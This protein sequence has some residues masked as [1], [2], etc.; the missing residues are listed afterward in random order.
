MRRLSWRLSSLELCILLCIVVRLTLLLVDK[1]GTGLRV[2]QAD[3]VVEWR[4]APRELSVNEAIRPALPSLLPPPPPPSPESSP[5]V[6]LATSHVVI[7]MDRRAHKA[8]P[9]DGA[10]GPRE[11]KREVG[12]LAGSEHEYRSCCARAWRDPS[13]NA[14]I[15]FCDQETDA[16]GDRAT[17]QLTCFSAPSLKA[18]G[19][20]SSSTP[21]WYCD[22]R[23]LV[24]NTSAVSIGSDDL[25]IPTPSQKGL[26]QRRALLLDCPL[27][28]SALSEPRRFGMLMRQLLPVP[29]AE[30]RASSVGRDVLAGVLA[31]LGTDAHRGQDE[32]S[33]DEPTI[34]FVARYSVKNFF[35][36]HYDLL[37]V[38]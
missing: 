4:N 13:R 33:E 22:A 26:W 19:H 8:G 21:A 12:T 6:R 7:T 25:T 28:T 24:V 35:L 36:A 20:S 5:A 14:A 2:I 10:T 1:G 16:T 15:E 38:R 17:S 18:I 29:L 11:R 27:R 9:D 32:D 30:L 31:R 3:S 23:R 37:Q 34:V